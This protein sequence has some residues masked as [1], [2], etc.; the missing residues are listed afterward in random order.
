MKNWL[1]GNAAERESVARRIYPQ[2]RHHA[3]VGDVEAAM[4]SLTRRERRLLWLWEIDNPPRK[5]GDGRDWVRY[6]EGAYE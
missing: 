3:T 2:A 5:T 4:A 1:F 6:P